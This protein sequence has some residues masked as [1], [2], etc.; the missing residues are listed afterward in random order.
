MPFRSEAQRK[1]MNAAAARGDIKQSTVDEFNKASKGMHLPE[2]V[3][4]S[5]FNRTKN[6]MKKGG[7]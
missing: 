7:K 6:K 2:H 5:K 4:G 1:Y 3:K